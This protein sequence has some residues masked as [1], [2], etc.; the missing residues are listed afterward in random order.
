M[1]EVPASS[2]SD[3]RALIQVSDA[4]SLGAAGSVLVGAIER[5]IGTLAAP[6]LRKREA[7]AHMQIFEEWQD[8][9]RSV[10]DGLSQFD[11]SLGDRTVLRMRREGGRQQLN[12]ER[13]GW[14]SIRYA[15]SF[16]GRP[17]DRKFESVEDEWLDRFWRLAQDVS[18]QDM[19]ELW[20]RILARRAFEDTPFSARSLEAMSLISVN[21]ARR[22]ECIAS[23][24]WWW[25]DG[26]G[27][28]GAT[29][30]SRFRE[31]GVSGRKNVHNA[32]DVLQKSAELAASIGSIE[33][34]IFG[35]AG[36]YTDAPSTIAVRIASLHDVAPM[37]IGSVNFNLRGFNREFGPLTV[38]RTNTCAVAKGIGLSAVGREIFSLPHVIPNE[39]YLTLVR[40]GLALQGLT[41]E[42]VG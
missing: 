41:L 34:D 11:L 33:E 26:Q 28:S 19:Q 32:D 15:R 9:L 21:E 1:S 18:R 39:Q 29:I 3:Q 17:P 40:S 16:H 2:G 10:P 30:V 5:G 8:T 25:N 4:L 14:E 37:R 23:F 20:G 36:L 35:P 42:A 12:R 38:Q 27:R 13:I 31:A 6:W 7:R 24:V 22:I